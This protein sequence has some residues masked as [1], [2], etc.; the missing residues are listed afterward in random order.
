MP[1]TGGGRDTVGATVA[2]TL[3]IPLRHVIH[4]Q[5]MPMKQF[6][7]RLAEAAVAQYVV[8]PTVAP[9]WLLPT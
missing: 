4:V 3:T 8:S 6:K 7:E 2:R 9:C 1:G 5:D